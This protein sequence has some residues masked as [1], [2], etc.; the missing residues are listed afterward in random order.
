MNKNSRKV[1]ILAT[2]IDRFLEFGEPVGSKTVS[3]IL[4]D[5]V[6]SATIR[7]EM[8]ELAIL[9]YLL[10]PH[11]SSGR[12][13]SL[14]G[15]RFYVDK[16][17]NVH[18][19]SLEEEKFIDESLVGAMFEPEKFMKKTTYVLAQ[20]TFSTTFSVTKPSLTS[21]I[22]EIMLMQIGLS[23][24]ILVLKIDS[25]MVK[26]L[27]FKC[28][29][30]LSPGILKV[31]Q[32]ILTEKFCGLSLK[33]L[34]EKFEEMLADLTSATTR[35]IA[36]IIKALVSV[37]K[38][39]GEAEVETAGRNNLLR[40]S[41][42]KSESIMKIFD[43]LDNGENMVKTFFGGDYHLGRNIAVYIGDENPKFEFKDT[44]LFATSFNFGGRSGVLGAICPL[45]ANF[46][47][48]TSVLNHVS[49]TIENISRF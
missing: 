5:R 17:L 31:F 12:V 7:N 48:V 28:D 14:Q 8:A 20:L 10:K 34:S 46:S 37:S 45:P 4:E 21:K 2:I 32:D 26:S 36:P 38:Q 15:Y 24:A 9:G 49:R 29:Y 25:G 18:R 44:T 30:S 1:K 23:E 27:I 22:M 33:V 3:Q 19:L 42:I 11:I 35:L 16:L 47:R 41:G 43:F 6:S 39:A 40:F 13:P